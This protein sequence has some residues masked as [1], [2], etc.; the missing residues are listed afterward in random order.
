MPSSLVC[1]AERGLS[2]YLIFMNSKTDPK[3]A[4]QAAEVGQYEDDE[5]TGQLVKVLDTNKTVRY[6]HA[7]VSREQQASGELPA[8]AGTGVAAGAGAGTTKAKQPGSAARRKGAVTLP[9]QQLQ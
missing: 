4:A 9:G 2:N 1:S 5:A 7:R 6:P 3:V 8:S